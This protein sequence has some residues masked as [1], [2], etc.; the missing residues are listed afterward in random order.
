MKAQVL[1]SYETKDFDAPLDDEVTV[2]LINADYTNNVI[3]I[4]KDYPA[5][6]Q[7]PL[8]YNPTERIQYATADG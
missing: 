8:G 6:E 2:H 5:T 4:T 1:L 3:D 7:Y